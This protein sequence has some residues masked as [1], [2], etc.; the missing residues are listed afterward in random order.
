MNSLQK[1]Y[2]IGLLAVAALW[3]QGCA[4]NLTKPACDPKPASC[5]M[6][7][8][9]A[10]Q[11]EPVTI[12]PKFAASDA[13]QKAAVKIDEHMFKKIKMVIPCVQAADG[14]AG[15]GTLLIT[16]L[17][18][19]IKFIGGFARFMVGG[20]AGSSAVLMKVTF[21]DAGTGDVIAEPEFYCDASSMAGG[22]SMGRS[23]NLMLDEIADEVAD[24][25]RLNL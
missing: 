23:D 9:Q 5:K 4:T 12:S 20:M 7:T 21:S 13:N 3:C 8:F 2:L 6:T 25:I 16:P 11:L 17:I 18:K 14:T 1:R 24:Y 10:V 15:A 19:E 22:Y